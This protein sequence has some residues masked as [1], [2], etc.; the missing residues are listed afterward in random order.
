M[1]TKQSNA[2][3]SNQNTNQKKTSR[4]VRLGSPDGLEQVNWK[5]GI[6]EIVNQSNSAGIYGIPAELVS[7]SLKDKSGNN[8]TNMLQF[9]DTFLW[10]ECPSDKCTNHKPYLDVLLNSQEDIDQ[11][12]CSSCQQLMEVKLNIP[13]I[14]ADE[15][16]DKLVV[17]LSTKEICEVANCRVDDFVGVGDDDE[18]GQEMLTNIRTYFRNLIQYGWKGGSRANYRWV[19]E[20]VPLDPEQFYFERYLGAE[21]AIWF[22]D[23]HGYY[24]NFAL[25]IL[26]QILTNEK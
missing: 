11:V 25:F 8:I 7:F 14:L 13:L 9:R 16:G 2:V 22:K 15:N 12:H 3:P 20:K 6:I 24:T 5:S 18:A 1:A 17:F 4:V 26:K 23:Q 19:L 21:N 10:F